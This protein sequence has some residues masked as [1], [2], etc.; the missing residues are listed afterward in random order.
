MTEH[1]VT[2]DTQNLEDLVCRAVKKAMAEYLPT[3]GSTS[4][5]TREDELIGTAEVARLLGCSTRTVATYRSRGLF[6]VVMRGPKKAL[7]YKSQIQA[8]R[9]ANTRPCRNTK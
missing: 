2:I 6:Q 9:D 5:R 3:N 7:Y 1:K 4:I 8:F